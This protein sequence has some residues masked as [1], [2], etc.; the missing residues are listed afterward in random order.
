MPDAVLHAGEREGLPGVLV[1]VS[2]FPAS[3]G[4]RADKFVKLLPGAG[5]R[6]VVLTARETATPRSRALA[7]ALYP[8]ERE[9]HAARSL[10]WSY[11]TERFLDRGPQAKYY[12]L[13]RVLSFP[14][15]CAYV[16]DYMVRWIPHAVRIAG[17]LVSEKRIRFVLTSSPPE[18]THL[19]GL[20]LKRRFGTRWVADFRDLWT[21]KALL[22]RP[23]SRAHD[24]WIRRLE[25][26]ILSAADHVVANTAEN[27][28]WYVR[29][30]GVPRAR[31]TVIPNGF[32]RDDLQGVTPNAEL[33]GVFQIGHMGFLDKHTYPWK[34]FLDAVRMLA[35]RVGVDKVR[36]VHCGF[37][38]RQV[39]AYLRE[40]G[41]HRFLSS[42][43][44]LSHDEAMRAVAA[45]DLRVVLLYENE[46]SGCIVPAKLYNYLIMKG[47]IL[48]IAPETGALARIVA[49][50]RTGTVV[51]P[52]SSVDRVYL[53]LR[54]YYESWRRRKPLEE[55]DPERIAEYDRRR[56]VA[57]L[58]GILNGMDSE[59]PRS[60]ARIA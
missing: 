44:W 8:P 12:G 45:T 58:A 3:G 26:T 54:R 39:D 13:L 10:G 50:T 40:T 29:H 16:P 22:Y 51:S 55:P 43:G 25:R 33:S 47:P 11:F 32:D 48:A 52:R 27:G 42:S 19:I 9:I 46:Y 14:E 60:R 2:A 37:H 7:A 17:R 21:Q 24:R 38:S 30:M 4:S 53:A 5:F 56:H 57:Q 23:A 34:L 49:E 1:A 15:R 36:L 28:D 59:A 6:P 35:D 31:V 41:A 18:S 20:A